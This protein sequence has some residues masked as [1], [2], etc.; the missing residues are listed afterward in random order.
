MAVA[1]GMYSSLA[2]VSTEVLCH[3]YMHI[4]FSC[5]NGYRIPILYF[6]VRS[7]RVFRCR[8]KQQIKFTFLYKAEMKS[9]RQCSLLF[10]EVHHNKVVLY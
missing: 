7:N 4:A 3:T 6:R 5:V 9:C 8:E 2:V 1:T 10:A